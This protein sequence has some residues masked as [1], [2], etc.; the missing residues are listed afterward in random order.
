MDLIGGR[1]LVIGTPE[2]GFHDKDVAFLDLSFLCGEAFAKLEITGVDYSC[3]GLFYQN[4]GPAEDM[5][6]REELY[7]E[8]TESFGLVIFE[9][10]EFGLSVAVFKQP[11]GLF[12]GKDL[13]MPGGMIRMGVRDKAEVSF[14]SRVQPQG[15]APYVDS[16]LVFD[17]VG[18]GPTLLRC[19]G[20]G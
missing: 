13:G 4:L 12:G 5:S 11:G 19:V 8:S 16:I 2:G 6:R 3:S 10:I 14:S 20:A 17:H 15:G 18:S 1:E 9:Q 7:L